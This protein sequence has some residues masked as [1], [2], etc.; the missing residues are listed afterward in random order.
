MDKDSVIGWC[1]IA[2]SL[3]L[4]TFLTFWSRAIINRLAEKRKNSKKNNIITKRDRFP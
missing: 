3:G 1:V 2:G 4:I